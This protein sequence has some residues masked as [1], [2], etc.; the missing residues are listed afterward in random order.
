MLNN[1]VYYC[2][3][4]PALDQPVKF[5]NYQTPNPHDTYLIAYNKQLLSLDPSYHL[6]PC[7]HH[8]LPMKNTTMH[9]RCI[10]GSSIMTPCLAP[11]QH[12]AK[13]EPSRS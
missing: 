2:S 1:H 6:E 12:I 5:L 4:A 9:K 7:L 8:R 13:I 10:F 11:D 3:L